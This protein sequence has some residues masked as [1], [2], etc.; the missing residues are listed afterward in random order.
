M[1]HWESGGSFAGDEIPDVD[2]IVVSPNGTTRTV[3]VTVSYEVSFQGFI[4]EEG[5]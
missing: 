1:E 3:H 4:K 2:L 5:P